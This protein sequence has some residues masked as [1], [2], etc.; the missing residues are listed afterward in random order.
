MLKIKRIPDDYAFY[1]KKYEKLEDWPEISWGN[2]DKAIRVNLDSVTKEEAASW[3][4]GDTLLLSGTILTGR[5]AAHK[6]MVELFNSGKPLPDGV[7]FDNKF[8]VS[9]P[10]IVSQTGGSPKIFET[11]VLNCNSGVHS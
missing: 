7:N 5:D 1:C 10:I 4:T 8:I 9:I 2:N 3:K 6:K 11:R